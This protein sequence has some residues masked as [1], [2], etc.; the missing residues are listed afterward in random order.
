MNHE[1][2]KPFHPHKEKELTGSPL[3]PKSFAPETN[4]SV[5]PT[6]PVKLEEPVYTVC[7]PGCTNT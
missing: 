1:G 3:E 2:R 6:S 4:V 5:R 7:D